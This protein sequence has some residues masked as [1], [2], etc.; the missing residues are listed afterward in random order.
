MEV[1]TEIKTLYDDKKFQLECG[2]DLAPVQVAYQTYGT[3]NESKDNVIL[4]CHALTG[5]AHAAGFIT[6]V[7]TDNNSNPDLLQVYS[8]LYK[9]KPGWWNDLIGPDKLFDT[10]RYFVICS[11]ILGSCYG[12]TGPASKDVNGKTYKA[13]FPSITVRDIVHVQ[14]YLLDYLGINKLHSVVGGSL[15]G[16]QVLEWALLYPEFISSIIPIATSAQHSAWAIGLNETA[17]QAIEN[18]PVWNGGNYDKQPFDGLSLA[19]EIAMISYRSQP[20]FQKK[21]ERKTISDSDNTFKVESYLRYQGKKIVERFDANS[22][23]TITDTMDSHDITRGRGT[24]I[25]TLNSIKVKT[26]SIGIDSD[27]LYPAHE[28]KEFVKHIPNSEYAEITSIHG[29]D[30]FLIEFDQLNAI[31]KPFLEDIIT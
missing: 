5:N 18:D 19:R 12:T 26:L 4:I 3:L 24:I 8:K 21:F 16:M 17:R 6:E 11:N 23:L 30:A 2:A 22:Y 7:E 20:S 31:I 27:L 1:T 10:N 13:D 25:D 9:G 28:Q 14:K 29:H 15:G